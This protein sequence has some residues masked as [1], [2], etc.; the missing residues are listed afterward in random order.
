M[1]LKQLLTAELARMEE[2]QTYKYE[3]ALQSSQGGVVKVGGKEV[4]MLASNN[5]LG[6]SN[7]PVVRK[8]AIEGIKKYGYGVAAARFLCGTQTIHQELEKKI[9]R[10]LRTE[11]TIL[12]SS[13]F[14]AN[15][16]FFSALTNEKLG[17]ENYKDVIY[18]DRLN[19]A[20]IIDGQRLCRSETTDKK[21]YNHNDAEHLAQLLEEDKNKEYR[22]RMIATDGVFSMEG[23]KA[24]LPRLIELARTYNAVLFVDDCH[25]IGVV[26]K[27]GRGVAEEQGVLGK[28]DV[29]VG[30]LGKA[31]GG[32]SG[33]Y[34]SGSKEMIAYLRQKARTYVFS[35][36]LPPSIV[37]ATSAAFDLL[38]KDKSIVKRLHDNTEYFRKEVKALGFKI[39]EGNHP[40]VPVML[41]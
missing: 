29:L 34:I 13:T 8:A 32:A 38:M 39:L 28:I 10:F 14:A 3:T 30:T 27:T 24:P 5:Y 17:V 6:M 26:G 12:F 33:G 19:H 40:I 2:S 9:S 37:T 15:V 21:V 11:D 22:L 1:E 25:G 23:D 18:S 36:S 7:H 20:S 31:I 41:G 35:N 4:V 16:G